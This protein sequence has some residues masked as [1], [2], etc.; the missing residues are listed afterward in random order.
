[1]TRRDP[2]RERV[3]R[4]CRQELV[5]YSSLQLGSRLS[6]DNL[7]PVM[8]VSGIIFLDRR[9]S[10]LLGYQARDGYRRL[11]ETLLNGIQNPVIA[12]RYARVLTGP[13][14]LVSDLNPSLCKRG[15]LSLASAGLTHSYAVV[16]VNGLV[17]L[18]DLI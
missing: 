9:Q 3:R 12:Y 2:N 5:A 7:N 4:E 13:S 16:K 17:S 10:G 18:G 14:C 8:T 11:L 6:F 15:D 1:M